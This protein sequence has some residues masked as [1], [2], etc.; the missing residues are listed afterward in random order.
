VHR[1]WRP[2]RLFRVRTST[3]MVRGERIAW[4]E[5]YRYNK[6]I[7]YKWVIATETT[8]PEIMP[9]IDRGHTF[10][11]PPIGAKRR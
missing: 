9:Y 10:H 8:D 3:G 5:K 2:C 4:I 6:L 1:D 11:Q 7:R